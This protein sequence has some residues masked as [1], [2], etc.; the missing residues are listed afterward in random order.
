M[1]YWWHTA[2]GKLFDPKGG[3]SLSPR[4]QIREWKGKMTRS[5]VLTAKQVRDY[6]LRYPDKAILCDY[7]H[8]DGWSAM[9]AGVSLPPIHPPGH[10]SLMA[11][12]PK[13]RPF[14]L[15]TGL[16]D[17][18]WAVAEPDRHYIVYSASGAA[19]QLD[20]SGTQNTFA[21][22]WVNA[23]TGSWT[24]A[25]TVSGGEVH[26]LTPPTPGRAFLWLSR[27]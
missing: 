26:R 15:A 10:P 23:T 27:K 6:R 25:G 16:T 18:Q 8:L 19:I 9:I 1:K 20:L 11:A 13:M 21:V 2:N 7:D 17:Q 24:D 4:Q 5:D 12:L 14:D 22:R 3:Q